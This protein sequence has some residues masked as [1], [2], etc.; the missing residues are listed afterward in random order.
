[1]WTAGCWYASVS[2]VHSALA[3]LSDEPT[4]DSSSALL[5]VG[6]AGAWTAPSCVTVDHLLPCLGT[7]LV[8]QTR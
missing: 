4:F 8:W 3:R 2:L 5:A 7:L 1:M 6:A